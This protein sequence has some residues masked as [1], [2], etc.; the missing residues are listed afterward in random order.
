MIRYSLLRLLNI[1]GASVC[2]WKV[3]FHRS[4]RHELLYR[5]TDPIYRLL[6]RSNSAFGGAFYVD[7]F[8]LAYDCVMLI[9]SRCREIVTVHK[10]YMI[11]HKVLHHMKNYIK[12]YKKKKKMYKVTLRKEIN[13]ILKNT[14][15]GFWMITK[16][17]IDYQIIQASSDYIKNRNNYHWATSLFWPASSAYVNKLIPNMVF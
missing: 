12:W 5:C 8:G 10:T 13:N 9:L 17:K 1:A 4:S 2:F 6:L 15:I 3:L 14:T 7:M 16:E 11:M